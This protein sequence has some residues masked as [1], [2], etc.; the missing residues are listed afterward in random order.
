MDLTLRDPDILPVAKMIQLGVE[1][2]LSPNTTAFSAA[3][4]A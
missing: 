2:D 3:A 4:G 1:V